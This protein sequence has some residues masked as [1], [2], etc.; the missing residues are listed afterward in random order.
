MPI[1]PGH[2]FTSRSSTCSRTR[3]AESEVAAVDYCECGHMHL[4]LGPF[5]LR[6]T[7]EALSGLLGTLGHAVA[8]HAALGVRGRIEHKPMLELNSRAP[9]KRGAA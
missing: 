1:A 6:I 2:S 9:R 8:S 4:H 3:L 5:S 7:P